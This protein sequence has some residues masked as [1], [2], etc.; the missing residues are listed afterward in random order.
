M[1]GNEPEPVAQ[2]LKTR[3]Q[4]A[5]TGN[6]AQLEQL[7]DQLREMAASDPDQATAI[8]TALATSRDLG[9][10]EAAAIY[11]RYLFKTRPDQATELLLAL[12]FNNDVDV[13]SRALDTLNKVTSDPALTPTQAARPTA[14]I[15]P[16]SD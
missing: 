5:E 7:D 8:L 12:I 10:K 14:Q 16:A 15:T 11:V 4:L 1:V 3:H 13:K 2:F 9:V 6:T